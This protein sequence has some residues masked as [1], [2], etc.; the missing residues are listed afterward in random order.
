MFRVRNRP[1]MLVL[2]SMMDLLFLMHRNCAKEIGREQLLRYHPFISQSA[3]WI[4]LPLPQHLH[5]EPVALDEVEGSEAEVVN[6]TR[7]IFRE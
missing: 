5:C 6:R 4:L 1:L 3:Q 2:Q 7:M